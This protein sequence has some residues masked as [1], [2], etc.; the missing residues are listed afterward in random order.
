MPDKCFA[1]LGDCISRLVRLWL[2]MIYSS[3]QSVRMKLFNSVWLWGPPGRRRCKLSQWGRTV[4]RDLH[5]LL[6]VQGSVGGR[7]A[8]VRLVIVVDTRAEVAAVSV[9]YRRPEKTTALGQN[10]ATIGRVAW[11]DV[12]VH[13]FTFLP[14]YRSAVLEC[15]SP[16]RNRVL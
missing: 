9:V 16:C 7:P 15:S 14:E 3:E 2:L 11:V 13:L 5:D 4:G 10:V 1:W 6:H 12:V 8:W